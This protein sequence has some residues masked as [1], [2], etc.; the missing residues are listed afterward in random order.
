MCL[1]QG[2]FDLVHITAQKNFTTVLFP[3]SSQGSP[4]DLLS[5]PFPACAA[6][7]S[8]QTNKQTTKQTA[9]REGGRNPSLARV[10]VVD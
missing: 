9:D 1:Y 8:H 7:A 6:K 3:N 5:P 4:E 2:S 10:Q